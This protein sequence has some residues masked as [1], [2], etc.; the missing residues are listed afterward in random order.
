METSWSGPSYRPPAAGSHRNATLHPSEHTD[1]ELLASA[2]A[3]GIVL[4]GAED[5]EGLARI[6]GDS[7]GVPVLCGAT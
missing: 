1:S 4:T 6:L 3:S 2:Q 7:L 5:L